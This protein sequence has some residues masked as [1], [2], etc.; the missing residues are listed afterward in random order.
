MASET[1]RIDNFLIRIAHYNP[2]GYTTPSHT[3]PHSNPPSTV[4]A[5]ASA[6][7]CVP[8]VTMRPRSAG[9]FAP[10]LARGNDR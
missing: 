5:R 3:A 2:R 7:S 8:T 10:C 6:L 9:A 1:A 4:G